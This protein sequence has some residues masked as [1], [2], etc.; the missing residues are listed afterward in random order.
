MS[1]R[2]LIERL[3]GAG[4]RELLELP[5]AFFR[6]TPGRTGFALRE[7]WYRAR[8]L[9]VGKRVKIDQGVSII[10][11]EHV[12]IGDDVW[13]DR[14]VTIIAGP[15]GASNGRTIHHRS[16]PAF[17]GVPGQLRIGDRVHVAPGVV[18]QAHGGVSIGP[19]SG[20]ASGARIYSLSHHHRDPA[21][22][23]LPTEFKF[24][25]LAPPDEQ[26]LIE[27][28]VVLGRATAVGLNA[29]VLPGTWVGDG[30]WVGAGVVLGGNV[31]P[32]SVALV[33]GSF[34]VKQKRPDR[35]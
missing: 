7:T 19:D 13:I 34:T 28:P 16:N 8:C 10:G 26:C 27:A 11:A 22:P 32:N 25:P 1:N 2:S 17:D 4:K 33:S 15:T 5:E 23:D 21:R 6:N 12:W 24:T 35:T 20:I 29:V 14:G 3:V 9:H 18:I 31:P 30:T